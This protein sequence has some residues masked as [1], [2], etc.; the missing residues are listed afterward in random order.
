M[1]VALGVEYSGWKYAGFQRQKH[2]NAV[3]NELERA[4]S[5]PEAGGEVLYP[6]WLAACP[7]PLADVL[8]PLTHTEHK[9]G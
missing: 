9:A 2:L 1:R 3:Q 4:L 6:L 7:E 8:A 5:D